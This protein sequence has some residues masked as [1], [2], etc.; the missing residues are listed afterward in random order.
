MTNYNNW[1][2]VIYNLGER[3]WKSTTTI[4]NKCR[5][6]KMTL[7]T[8]R[9]SSLCV[10]AVHYRMSFPPSQKIA[11][12]GVPSVCAIC[13]SLSLC[14]CPRNVSF[15]SVKKEHSSGLF[16]GV[17]GRPPEDRGVETGKLCQKCASPPPVP[18]YFYVL[19]L[20]AKFADL[21]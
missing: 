10:S 4:N 14:Y 8:P 13:A 7:T 1:F 12:G 20:V 18:R 17:F 9:R 16:V 2:A 11:A 6:H 19:S 21:L 3:K 15:R 5:S